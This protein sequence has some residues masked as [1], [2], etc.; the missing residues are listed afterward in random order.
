M[1][2]PEQNRKSHEAKGEQAAG[3]KGSYESSSVDH[4][5]FRAGNKD[6]EPWPRMDERESV[7]ITG[8]YR[9]VDDLYYL[10]INHAGPHIEMLLA[11]VGNGPKAGSGTPDL[12]RIEERLLRF[13]GDL[14][15]DRD[16][17]YNLYFHRSKTAIDDKRFGCGSLR[18]RSSGSRRIIELDLDVEALVAPGADAKLRKQIKRIARSAAKRYDA[19]PNFFEQ[20]L[21]HDW[22]LPEVR[23]LHWFPLTPTQISRLDE[24]IFDARIELNPANYQFQDGG[25]K[26][27]YV[28]LLPHFFDPTGLEPPEGNQQRRWRQANIA[29][30]LAKLV[31]ISHNNAIQLPVERG[32]IDQHQQEAWRQGTIAALEG[33]KIELVP[34][35]PRTLLTLTQD[36][37]DG[38]P[39]AADLGHFEEM[40]YLQPVAEPYEYSATME[41]IDLDGVAD[42]VKKMSK[43]LKKAVKAAKGAAKRLKKA[44]IFGSFGGLLTIKKEGLGA[45]EANY[46]IVLAGPKFSK[47]A[48]SGATVV[49]TS[50]KAQRVYG[51]AWRPEHIAG[52]AAFGEIG[53]AL[54][55]RRGKSG[56]LTI[57]RCH[58]TGR[59]ESSAPLQFNFSGWSDITAAGPGVGF[60]AMRYWGM[61]YAIDSQ[62]GE[63]EFDFPEP[64]PQSMKVSATGAVHFPINGATPTP[65]AMGLL[66]IFAASEMAVLSRAGVKLEFHGYA[67]QPGISFRNLILSRNRAISVYQYLKNILGSVLAAGELGDLPPEE[68][69]KDDWKKRGANDEYEIVDP[70][71]RDK[72]V[73]I[74]G[75]GEP[76]GES[77]QPE[78]YDSS[79]RRVDIVL[80]GDLQFSLVRE[81]DG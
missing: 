49:K 3:F 43:L 69:E 13:G 46:V 30:A 39:A 19:A 24:H 21:V 58:G 52:K 73:V 28:D 76:K 60:S 35:T 37:L 20:H 12:K 72:S 67:D 23:T 7:L 10:F 18:F 2:N 56:S 33:K 64:P 74:L 53:G 42:D 6:R 38:A 79:L 25:K 8:K 59:G 70:S 5:K 80:D 57:L 50:G 4:P 81:G 29:T 27:G 40:L 66:Q 62:G 63:V 32:G 77:T 16:D 17:M 45:F 14:H 34:G 1:A 48:G 47:S 15:P 71:P 55:G 36:V 54:F 65:E 31:W 75:H 22:V 78:I 68:Q 51:Q 9:H 44:A 26:F 41:I 11:L 61:I